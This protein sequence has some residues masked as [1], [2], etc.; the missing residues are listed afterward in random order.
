MQSDM[1]SYLDHNALLR[2]KY[3]LL[4]GQYLALKSKMCEDILKQKD[5]KD[6]DRDMHQV[7]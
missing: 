3:E 4:Q 1:Y 5:V 6:A 7:K 2:K